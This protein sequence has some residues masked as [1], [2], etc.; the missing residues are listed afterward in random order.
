MSMDRVAWVSVRVRDSFRLRFGLEMLATNGY[1]R[2]PGCSGRGTR[3]WDYCTD[4]EYFKSLVDL[5]SNG[6]G[7]GGLGM[8]QAIVTKILIALRA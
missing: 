8:C 3:N 5:N 7:N 6:N 1:E 4:S 2:I